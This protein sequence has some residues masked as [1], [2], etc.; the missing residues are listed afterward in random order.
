MD[1][2]KE[3]ERWINGWKKDGLMDGLKNLMNEKKKLRCLNGRR[4]GKSVDVGKVEY[5]RTKA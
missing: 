4:V 3:D 1:E 2:W 5:V